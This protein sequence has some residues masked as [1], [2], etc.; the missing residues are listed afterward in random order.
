MYFDILALIFSIILTL[1]MMKRGG[2]RAIVSLCS[3]VISIVIAMNLYPVLTDVV[4]QTPLPENIEKTVS[5]AIAEK[6]GETFD[7]EALDAMPEFIQEAA[8][9][10]VSGKVQ[11]MTDALSEAVTKTIVQAL[12]FLAVVVL[13]KILLAFLVKSLDLIVKLPII[14]QFNALTG[15]LC[16]IG[17]SF[18]IIWIAAMVLGVMSASNQAAADFVKDSYVTAVMNG[19]SI[20]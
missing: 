3:L 12:L 8:L 2:V 20:F 13:T 6:Y 11:D 16:G 14:K 1:I 9:G 15:I 7:L 4:Y 5:A 10:S 18:I 17:M 19:I